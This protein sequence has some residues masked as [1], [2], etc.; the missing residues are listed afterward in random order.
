MPPSVERGRPT[1]DVLLL[2]GAVLPA[3]L[4]FAALLAELGDDVR[5]VIKDLELYA[6]DGPPSDYRLDLEVQ[7]VAR[8]AD[9]SGFGSFHLLGYSA[10]G[11]VA[12]AFAARDPG[13][14]R[15]LALLEPAWSGNAGRT[16]VRPPPPAPVPPPPGM[17]SRPAGLAALVPAL[18]AYDLPVDELRRFG[19]PVYYALG[20]LSNP[21]LYGLQA[22][23]LAGVFAR[24]RLDVFPERHHFDPPHRV[25]PRRLA[26]ALADHWAEG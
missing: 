1:H 16:G 17:S 7:A 21:Q 9:G 26:A 15:S 8:T 11:A 4:A 22:E 19:G 6:D 25:E 24:F 2:P 18:D 23:R 12:L 3:E 14:V 20:A 13:R 10:G 5:P